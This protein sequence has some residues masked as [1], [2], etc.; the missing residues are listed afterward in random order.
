MNK[1]FSLI[2]VLC[3]VFAGV[4]GA[5]YVCF[6]CKNKVNLN[7]REFILIINKEKKVLFRAGAKY[8]ITWENQNEIGAQ[9]ENEFYI[10]EFIFNKYTGNATLYI[11]DRKK[12][13]SLN[14]SSVAKSI[15][16]YI[17]EKK[18]SLL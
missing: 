2:L 5:I 9:N 18:Q 6:V 12:N 16:H 14:F 4:A 10:G 11:Y 17:C 8:E 15:D 3:L 7:E 13:K 1:L